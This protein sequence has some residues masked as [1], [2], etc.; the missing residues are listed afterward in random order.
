[1]CR[2]VQ[3]VLLAD[4]AEALRR[5]MPYIRCLNHFI[6]DDKGLLQRTTV[7]TLTTP[8]VL[9]APRPAYLSSPASHTLRAGCTTH[10]NVPPES[11]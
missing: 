11:C 2:L 10:V 1:M 9:A 3:R 7:R 4:D 5:L 8:C 6:L